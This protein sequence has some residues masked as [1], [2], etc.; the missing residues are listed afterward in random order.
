MIKNN[1]PF[2]MMAETDH[3]IKMIHM[4]I[5]MGFGLIIYYKSNQ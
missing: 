3:L 2:K 4:K 5:R 1:I